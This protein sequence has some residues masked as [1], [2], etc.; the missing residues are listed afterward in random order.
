LE[1]PLILVH[2]VFL[3]ELDLDFAFK[4]WCLKTSWL[5]TVL[6]KRLS[7]EYLASM[8]ELHL[9]TFTKDLFFDFLVIFFLPVELSLFRDSSQSG[10]PEHSYKVYLRCHDNHFSS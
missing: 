4:S 6:S 3:F 8:R 5:K 2:F 7:T 1:E 9:Q 10:P